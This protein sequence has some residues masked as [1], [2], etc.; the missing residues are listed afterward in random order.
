M[1][2]RGTLL[3]CLLALAPAWAIASPPPEPEQQALAPETVSL[4]GQLREAGGSRAPISGATV[5]IVDAP[6]DVRPGK[7]AREPLDPEAVAWVLQTETDEEGRFTIDEVPL[8]KIRVV[9]VAGGYERFE[10][11]AEARAE[12]ASLELFVQP[13][14]SGA[15]RTEVEVERER[16][17]EPTHVIDGQQARHYAGGGDDP[18]LVALNLPGVRA[19]ASV[20]C[21]CA[22]ATRPRR[23]C[24]S[25][26]TRS[27]ARSMWCRSPACSRHR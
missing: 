27:R 11:W 1:V 24:T 13:E 8:G 22:A 21:R 3:A 7:P 26:A 6:A 5:M 18:V 9:I 17:T 10:Q 23:A 20:F 4:S 19:A 2:R 14:Q 15:Y 25:T 16:T 12:G